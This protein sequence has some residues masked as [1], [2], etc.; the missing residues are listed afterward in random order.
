MAS[1]P[2]AE[3]GVTQRANSPQLKPKESKERKSWPETASRTT[4]LLLGNKAFE[5]EN[6]ADIPDI[7]HVDC[8]EQLTDP[9]RVSLHQVK[10]TLQVI[11]SLSF[12]VSRPAFTKPL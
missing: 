3:G 10:S 1:P 6:A 9:E 8:K 7:F 2:P 12:I 5:A 11:L 4:I